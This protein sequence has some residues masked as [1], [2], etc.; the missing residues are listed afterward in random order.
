MNNNERL[1]DHQKFKELAA[2]AQRGALNSSERLELSGHLRV[3]DSC[4][5]AYA[6][7]S[8]L[9]SE[10]MPFLAAAYG[11][12]DESEGWDERPVR[13]RLLARVRGTDPS[14]F[15][16]TKADPLRLG[17][18][19]PGKVAAQWMG[20]AAAACVLVGVALGAYHLG[21]RTRVVPEQTILP[22]KNKGRTSWVLCR[23]R[24]CLNSRFRSLPANRKLP[25][26]GMHCT[27]RKL[28][29]RR[30]QPRRQASRKNSAV[31]LKNATSW[32]ANSTT[33]SR[34]IN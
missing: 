13:N 15:E 24:R 34:R 27:L 11:H 8:L 28:V 10:G 17:G 31:Y 1:D 29:P 18:K 32:L 16:A 22:P 20:V 5:Q 9:S 7:Y 21:G 2:F 33:L 30:C 26:C 6:E 14:G 4:Q 25:D 3:C 23:G 12:R 19:V